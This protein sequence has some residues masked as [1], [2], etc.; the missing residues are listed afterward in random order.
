MNE[1]NRVFI[2]AIDE[3]EIVFRPETNEIVSVL[4]TADVGVETDPTSP[5]LAG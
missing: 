1:A 3:C 4:A 5:G 2:L